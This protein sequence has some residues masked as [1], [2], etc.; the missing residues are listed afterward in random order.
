MQAGAA[1]MNAVH[2]DLWEGGGCQ[3]TPQTLHLT[4]H[5]LDPKPLP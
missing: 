2:W 1:V 5:P 4:L 3:V